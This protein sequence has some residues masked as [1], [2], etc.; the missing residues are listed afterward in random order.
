MAQA[1]NIGFEPLVRDDQ[2]ALRRDRLSWVSQNFIRSE[3]L[4][5]ANAMIVAGQS[6]LPITTHWGDG[7]VASA[8]GLRFL[9]PKTAIHAGPNP[10]YFGRGRGI[11]W[12][13]MLSDQYSGL[14]ASVVPG[15]LRDSLAVLALLLDQETELEPTRIMTDN[16]AYSD[17][18]F[19]LF[20]LLG[21]QFCP[22]LADIG[23]ARL[24]RI[25]RS[26]YYGTL[27]TIAE[28]V[29][30]VKLITKN[31]EDLIRFAGFLKLGHLKA[32]GVAR[33]LQVRDRPTTLSKALMHLGRLIKTLHIL[34]YIDDEEFRRKVLVQLNRQEFRHKLARKIYHGERGEVRNALR[35]G[36]EDQLGSLGLALNAVIHWNA[37][38]MQAALAKLT[39]DGQIIDPSDIARLSPILWRHINFLGRYDIALPESVAYGGLRPLRDPTFEWDL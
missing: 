6:K 23:G 21:Y 12:Y 13:N 16:A 27:G 9:A 30:N 17:T 28:G 39:A 19:G 7:H 36:Q 2:P 32:E 37:I 20:W 5:A 25:D 29:I 38:Y 15:T 4:T 33:I 31:W 11:T 18:I 14:G 3:T 22:R 24:W 35:Q 1:C 10:K 26:A 34:N 8:D